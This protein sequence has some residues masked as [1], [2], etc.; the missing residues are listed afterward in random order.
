MA[1]EGE[2]FGPG[3]GFWLTSELELEGDSGGFVAFDVDGRSDD[4]D[5]GDRCNCLSFRHVKKFVIHMMNGGDE[6]F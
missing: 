6:L 5:E 3:G 2:T 4:R 1:W